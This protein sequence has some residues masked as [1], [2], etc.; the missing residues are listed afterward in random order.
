MRRQ[1]GADEVDIDTEAETASYMLW[2]PTRIDFGAILKA[3]KDAGY[4][5][6]GITLDIA[7]EVTMADCMHCA[8]T[9]P[10]LTIRETGQSF[11]LDGEFETG[12]KL[13]VT[14]DVLGWDG[15]HPVLDI[16]EFRPRAK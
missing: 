12:A 14:A 9:V 15:E 11:E 4:T 13:R 6:T 16:I 7:G 2:N 3:S 5:L 8:D 10:M 1:L